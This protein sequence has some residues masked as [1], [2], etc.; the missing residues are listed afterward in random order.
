[1][2]EDPGPPLRPPDLAVGEDLDA[3]LALQGDVLRGRPVFRLP[4][5]GLAQLAPLMLGPGGQ[6]PG[7]PQHAADVLG[8]N[9]RHHERPSPY[10]G[11]KCPPTTL[12]PPAPPA[13]RRP[14][15]KAVHVDR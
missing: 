10:L 8:V 6:Q 1:R 3:R 7:L 2:L 15:C 4:Q 13:T 9:V 11:R 5:P 12:T 14:S